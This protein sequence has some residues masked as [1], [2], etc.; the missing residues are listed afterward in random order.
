LNPI[1]LLPGQKVAIAGQNGCGKSVLATHLARSMDRVL[2]YD[3]KWDP[4]A[5]MPNAAV[6]TTAKEAIAALPGRVIYRPDPV[7]SGQIVDRFDEIVRKIIRG[8]G[9]HGIVVHELGNLGTAFAMGDWHR[10]AITQ[11]R[12]LQITMVE[13]TQRPRHIPIVALSEAQHLVCFTLLNPDDRD[14][15]AGYMGQALRPSALPLD[16][17]WWYRGPDLRLRLHSPLSLASH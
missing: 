16:F 6:V 10:A 5:D 17:S 13:L 3:P 1:R 11:G 9:R 8:G 12:S 15:M 14:V 7:E 4:S 2:V